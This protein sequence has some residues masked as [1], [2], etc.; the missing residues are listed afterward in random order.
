MLPQ[1]L[2]E[3]AS[4]VDADDSWIPERTESIRV[5]Q[6]IDE[7]VLLLVG[8]NGEPQTPGDSVIFDNLTGGTCHTTEENQRGSLARNR[9]VGSTPPLFLEIYLL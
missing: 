2:A 7:R 5:S 8:A 6:A 4:A 9:G 1:S 3:T